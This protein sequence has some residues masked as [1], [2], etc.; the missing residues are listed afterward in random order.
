[1]IKV[2]YPFKVSSSERDDLQARRKKRERYWMLLFLL[3]GL[4]SL[5][6]GGYDAYQALRSYTWPTVEG[7]IV[8]S[9]ITSVK[10]PGETPTY[11]PD[12]RYA[13]RVEGKEYT[14]DRIFFG[15]Y[16]T[17]SSSSAQAV[18]DKYKV[19]TSVTVYYDP[20]NPANAILERGARWASF[21][22]LAFGLLFVVVGLGGFLLW[23]TLNRPKSSF[24]QVREHK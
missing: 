17:G 2:T 18:I 12:I 1:M 24:Y 16:G 19:G 23:D 15:E 22:L 14:G 21:A 20:R 11:Y 10:H 6:K 8:S 4:I 9:T 3:G 7:K 5:G 13:Y